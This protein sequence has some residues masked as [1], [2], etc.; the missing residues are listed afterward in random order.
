MSLSA[1][2]QALLIYGLNPMTIREQERRQ[3]R[4]RRSS[5]RIPDID[6]QHEKR[7]ERQNRVRETVASNPGVLTTAIE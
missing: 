6:E 1:A 5:P 3:R 7:R 2:S 4:H